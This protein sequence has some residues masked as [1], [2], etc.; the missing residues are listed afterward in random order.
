MRFQQLEDAADALAERL[1]SMVPADMEEGQIHVARDL[2]GAGLF[3]GL[4]VDPAELQNV[5]TALAAETSLGSV[6]QIMQMQGVVFV[7]EDAAVAVGRVVATHMRAT[8]AVGYVLGRLHDPEH[9]A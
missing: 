8:L 5:T 3:A 7:D 9:G 4:D 1:T 6:V 2:A